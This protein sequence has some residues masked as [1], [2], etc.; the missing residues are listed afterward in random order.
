MSVPT[1]PLL[2][3]LLARR[4]LWSV[5]QTSRLQIR[6]L[7]VRTKATGQAP[8]LVSMTS[9]ARRLRTCHLAIESIARGSVLPGRLILWL[10]DGIDRRT[11]P[12]GLARLQRRGLEIRFTT[13]LGPHTKYFHALGEVSSQQC[14]VT[15]DD[16]IVYPGS[17]LEGLLGA[18][19]GSPGAVWCY[20]ARQIRRS[21]TDLLP[22]QSWPYANSPHPSLGLFFTGVGGAAYP[23]ALVEHL[24]SAGMAFTLECPRADDVW[25]NGVA[26]RAGIRIGIVGGRSRSQTPV[27]GSQASALAETNQLGGDN[28]RLLAALFPDLP[29]STTDMGAVT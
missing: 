19:A 27:R 25:V 5:L 1:R 9:H 22:Y 7:L 15:A 3:F 4:W 6:N 23:E 14:L 26:A 11:V 12:R 10:P 28:D 13:D 17:W 29:A 2:W 20:R 8:V 21:A 24:T 18:R 16:D